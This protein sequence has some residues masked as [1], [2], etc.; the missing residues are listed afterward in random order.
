MDIDFVLSQTDGRPMYLQIIEKIVERIAVGE[1]ANGQQ[2]PSIRQLAV[3]LRVSAI[4]IKRAYLELER[5]GV[6]LTMH[7]K[8][9]FVAAGAELG[10]RQQQQELEQ[11]L[12]RAVAL[13]G[14]LGVGIEELQTRLQQIH[15]QQ[16]KEQA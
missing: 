4:T 5:Q 15:G 12:Q 3:A 8:G 2:L 11:V 16:S 7:G 9:S 14:L 10:A 1:W 6:I 13:S